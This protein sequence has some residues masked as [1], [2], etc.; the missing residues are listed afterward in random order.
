MLNKLNNSILPFK[1]DLNVQVKSLDQI[2]EN[3]EADYKESV[4]N[5]LPKDDT[6]EITVEPTDFVY[7]V[8]YKPGTESQEKGVDKKGITTIFNKDSF[9]G[10]QTLI[11][12]LSLT[13]RKSK[14]DLKNFLGNLELFLSPNTTRMFYGN[15]GEIVYDETLNTKTGYRLKEKK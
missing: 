2:K 11:D 9:Y 8:K 10:M 4:K 14:F 12:D 13:L 3:I 5:L 15:Q 7:R 6:F 1:G